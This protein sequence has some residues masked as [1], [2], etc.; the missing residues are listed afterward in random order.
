MSKFSTSLFIANNLIFR[1]TTALIDLVPS[2][3]N[4]PS[5]AQKIK[6]ATQDLAEAQHRIREVERALDERGE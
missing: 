4:W 2:S 6:Q 3:R 5:L 1:G